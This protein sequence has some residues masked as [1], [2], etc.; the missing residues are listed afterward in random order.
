MG[1][2][3]PRLT[4]ASNASNVP[5]MSNTATA[6]HDGIVVMDGLEAEYPARISATRW[7]GWANPAFT[8][9]V[10]ERVITDINAMSAEV[11]EGPILSWHIEDGVALVHISEDE[12]ESVEFVAPNADGRY[13]IGNAGWCWY[14]AEATS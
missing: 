13:P 2:R 11:G 10:A 4:I 9:E 14:E 5:G 6:D 12:G 8:P 1:T 3:S 7:N